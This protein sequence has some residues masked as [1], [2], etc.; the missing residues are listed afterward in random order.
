MAPGRREGGHSAWVKKAPAGGEKSKEEDESQNVKGRNLADVFRRCF[1]KNKNLFITVYLFYF[2]CV[3][4][5]SFVDMI[6]MRRL[7]V[8]TSVAPGVVIRRDP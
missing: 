8:I 6:D 7:R 1:V 2:L 3:V 4:Q 5:V